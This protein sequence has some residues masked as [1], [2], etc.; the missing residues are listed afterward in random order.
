MKAYSWLEFY[1]VGNKFKIKPNNGTDRYK[2]ERKLLALPKAE[3]K[4]IFK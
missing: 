1:A 2:V 4:V 3:A